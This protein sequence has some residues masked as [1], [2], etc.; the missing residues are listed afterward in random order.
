MEWK[1]FVSRWSVVGVG[2]LLLALALTYGYVDRDR[3]VVD[4]AEILLPVVVAA[5]VIG[6]GR[7]L[8]YS[9]FAD[10]DVA[11][12]ALGHLSGG[13]LFTLLMGWILFVQGLDGD[14]PPEPGYTMLHGVAIGT[15]ANGVLTAG[16][17]RLRDQR[18]RLQRRADQLAEQNDRLE[19]FASIVSHDLR[20]PLNVAHGRL[21]LARETGE[22]E[23][24]DA[25]ERALDRI[26]DIVE[27]MLTL[28]RQQQ[29]IG[30][31]RPTNLESVAA[32]AWQTVET[33]D[34]DSRFDAEVRILANRTRLQQLFEN[35]FRNAIDHGGES[36]AEV[37]VGSL[38]DG[39]YVED[40][41]VGIPEPDRSRVFDRGVSKDAGG[42]GLGLATVE[43]IAQAHGWSVV[44]AEGRDGGAR[45]EVTGVE[46][47]SDAETEPDG[48]KRSEGGARP[49]RGTG[50]KGGTRADGKTRSDAEGES[51]AR[52]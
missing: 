48:E 11:L 39:F 43:E 30:E 42:T 13:V 7:W 28:A 27:D 14:V 50:P 45:F 51:T 29:A 22:S 49:D 21:Q 19:D 38:D 5:G 3:I 12:V 47:A 33:R 46:V 36:L 1:R 52:Q 41:G 9:S 16:V 24:F 35:L 18:E 17:L 44:A 31:T 2:G 15:F 20:S 37:R 10:R 4:S 8:H 32:D 23:Q 34:V 6:F 40:D 26:E 25:A